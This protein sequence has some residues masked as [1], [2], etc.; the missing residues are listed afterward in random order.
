MGTALERVVGSD[1]AVVIHLFTGVIL[2]NVLAVA[3]DLKHK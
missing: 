3:A 2:M 1:L